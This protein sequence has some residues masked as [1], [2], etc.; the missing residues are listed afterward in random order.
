MSSPSQP[1]SGRGARPRQALHKASKFRQ[2]LARKNRIA[3]AL[4]AAGHDTVAEHLRECAETEHLC[5]CTSCG[6][7]WWVQTSCRQRICPI[8]SWRAS[9]KRSGVIER[10]MA[11]LKHAK[12]VTLT[13]PR[14]EEDPRDGIK[15]LRN[16]FA[17]L[18]R[19]KRLPDLAGGCY[20]IELIPKPQGWHI[21]MHLIVTSSYIP[22]SILQ[23]AWSAALGVRGAI[24]DIRDAGGRDTAKYVSKYITKGIDPAAPTSDYVRL[25]EAIKG[26]RLFALFG[27]W[28]RRLDHRAA[29]SEGLDKPQ[30]KCPI[31][32]AL[33]SC[34]DVRHGAAM[35]GREWDEIADFYLRGG[36]A[37][38]ARQ[39]SPS[40]PEPA[41][42]NASCANDE[43]QLW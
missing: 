36:Q 6:G 31:C 3:D 23:A 5:G 8:C 39:S 11:G 35:Y 21:H 7:R 38:R 33:G 16:A 20:S 30:S 17:T 10:W 22:H 24:C 19:N 4:E 37:S 18:R 43:V 14:W 27:S 34:F 12:F 9:R 29:L 42:L 2:H 25:Y 40:P 15:H 13:M 28:F 26:S 1:Q 41:P 32:G